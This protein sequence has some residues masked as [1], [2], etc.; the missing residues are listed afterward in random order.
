MQLWCRA[1]SSFILACLPRFLYA[2]ARSHHDEAIATSRRRCSHPAQLK[3]KP[4][5]PGPIVQKHV[6]PRPLEQQTQG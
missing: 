3:Q 2:P 5:V 6:S 1:P 4:K